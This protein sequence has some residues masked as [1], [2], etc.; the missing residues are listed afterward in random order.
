LSVYFFE[1]Y[2]G[3]KLVPRTKITLLIDRGGYAVI[4]ATLLYIVVA[5]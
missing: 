5:K 3:T 4:V 1:Y 2:H